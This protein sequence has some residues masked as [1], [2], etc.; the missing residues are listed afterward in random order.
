[1]VDEKLAFA[2]AHELAG[3][4]ATKQVSPVE[5]TELYFER[6][7][8]LDSQL[9]AYLALMRAEALHAARAAAEAVVRGDQRGPLHGV[10]CSVKS[11]RSTKIR[12]TAPGCRAHRAR[13]P[14]AGVA[15]L[16][17]FGGSNGAEGPGQ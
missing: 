14:G 16:S 4:I 15:A 8:R 17:A 7:E 11:L 1:M 2:P 10:P 13:V 6:I 12:A 9:H 3:L 5:I